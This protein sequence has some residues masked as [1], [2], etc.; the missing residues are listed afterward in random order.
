MNI[1]TIFDIRSAMN[2]KKGVKLRRNYITKNVSHISRPLTVRLPEK[3]LFCV[4]H[5]IIRGV[6]Q[7]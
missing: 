1:S 7:L 2:T 5:F 4:R 3:A 6:Y